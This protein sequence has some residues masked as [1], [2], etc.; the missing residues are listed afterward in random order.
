MATGNPAIGAGLH[1]RRTIF[2]LAESITYR[3]IALT[4]ALKTSQGKASHNTP[5][6]VFNELE[7]SMG[8]L[9]STPVWVDAPIDL[10]VNRLSTDQP[11]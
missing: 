4:I 3:L 5:R 6:P 10:I 7:A 11:P 1:N 9:K 8:Y 2:A